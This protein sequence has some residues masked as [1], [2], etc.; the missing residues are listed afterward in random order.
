[1]RVVRADGMRDAAV[2]RAAPYDLITANLFARLLRRLA[3]DIA[4]LA[5]P[6]GT[7]VLSGFLE[8]DRTAVVA[9]HRA[10]G[11]RPV[12]RLVDGDWITV[13]MSGLGRR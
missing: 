9:A 7:V 11:L 12:E 8:A 6:G 5:A 10:Q 13:A 4:G 3:P 2:A 1:M